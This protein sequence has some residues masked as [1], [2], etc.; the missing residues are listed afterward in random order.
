MEGSEHEEHIAQLFAT[1]FSAESAP[2]AN[3]GVAVGFS[4]AATGHSGGV[5]TMQHA[6]HTEV[7]I[8]ST[9][10][11]SSF[12][13]QTAMSPMVAQAHEQHGGSSAEST[14][15]HD[16]LAAGAVEAHVAQDLGSGEAH[17]ENVRSSDADSAD[18]VKPVKSQ[19]WCVVKPVNKPIFVALDGQRSCGCDAKALAAQKAALAASPGR[20]FASGATTTSC[21]ASGASISP[22]LADFYFGGDGQIPASDGASGDLESLFD[23]RGVA[24]TASRDS[25]LEVESSDVT[26]VEETRLA[27]FGA[28]FASAAVLQ[29]LGHSRKTHD[30]EHVRKRLLLQT[31]PSF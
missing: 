11:S 18:Q 5:H 2:A 16:G 15:S 25:V 21:H 12:V 29:F 23:L 8:S 13:V 27:G 22:Q 20:A 4:L 30:R 19:K 17:S 14:E 9:S 7:A 6:S 10:G 3:V 26:W 24:C 31:K 28:L 1:D